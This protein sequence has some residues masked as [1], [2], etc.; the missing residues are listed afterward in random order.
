MR[1]LFSRQ[2]PYNRSG[3]PHHVSPFAPG[4]LAGDWCGAGLASR[5]RAETR[6]GVHRSVL[7][8][9]LNSAYLASKT[10]LARRP[11]TDRGMRNMSPELVTM[12]NTSTSSALYVQR[13]R[14]VLFR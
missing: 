11:V 2:L 6:H 13:S 4:A 9:T 1:R 12:K 3:P 14:A 5:N 10:K 7:F 8:Q